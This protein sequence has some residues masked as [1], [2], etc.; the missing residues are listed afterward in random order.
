VTECLCGAAV[1]VDLIPLLVFAGLI[2]DWARYEGVRPLGYRWI[3]VV[4]WLF[5]MVSGHAGAIILSEH[6]D[7]GVRPWAVGVRVVTF[8]LGGLAGATI[9]PALAYVALRLCTGHH[10]DFEP[11][12]ADDED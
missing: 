12:A 10:P 9:A 4:G 11:I 8:Y 3:A 2:R 5:G 1:M 7:P 6:L